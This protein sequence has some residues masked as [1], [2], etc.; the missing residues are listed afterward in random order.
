VAK[1]SISRAWDET[2][3]VL[4]RDGR[5]L[6]TVAVA[7]LALPST[8]QTLVTP[9]TKPGELPPLGSWLIVLLITLLI[10]VVGQ[11]AIARLALGSQT[12]VGEA[13]SQG[14]K[15]L[16]PYFLAILLWVGPI[17][18]LLY[19][20]AQQMRPPTPSPGMAVLFLVLVFLLIF[21][22]VRLI[23]AVAVASAEPLG[24][25]GILQRSWQLTSGSWWRLFGFLVLFMI[26][27]LS[28]M[29][30]VGAIIGILA[31]IVLGPPEPMSVSALVIALVTQL[32]VAAVTVVFLVMLTRIY[33]QLAARNVTV[34]ETAA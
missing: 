24:P 19:F 25:I 7:L 12:S 30:A 16:L 1:L 6:S 18:V 31:G 15:R 20:A 5:L 26:A 28:V 4:G 21:L 27:V 22:A 17:A 34:P 10:G 33:L 2:R 32:A 3:D 8:V 13:I 11:L 29:I 23:I 14:A 9:V